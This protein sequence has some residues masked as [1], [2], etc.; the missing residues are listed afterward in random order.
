MTSR[1]TVEFLL[2]P[3]SSA[4]RRLRRTLAATACSGVVV[5]T[6][7]ELLARAQQ[8]YYI[9]APAAAGE[10]D[11]ALAES[12]DAFWHESF[13]KAPEE[14]AGAVRDALIDLLS[15]SHPG[16]CLESKGERELSPRARRM[17]GDLRELA[18]KLEE[19]LPGDLASLRNLLRADPSDAP[20]PLR[21]HRI[22]G[23]PYTTRWQDALIAKLN[24]DAALA[25]P[26]GDGRW[27]QVLAGCL[28]AKPRAKAGSA[29]A[30]LQARLFS[31]EDASVC[32]DQSAQWVRVRDFYQEAEVVAGMVQTLLAGNPDLRAAD[33][34]LLMPDS[35]E[36]SVAVEDAFRQAGLPLSGLAGERWRRDLGSEAVFHFLFCRQKPAPAMAQ[37]VCL[38]SLLMPWSAEDGA[39][40]AQRVMDGRYRLTAPDG[41]GRPAREMIKLIDGGDS[42]PATLSRALRDFASLLNGG[43][44][45]ADHSRRAKEAVDRACLRLEGAKGIDWP[46]LRRAVTPRYVRSGGGPTYTLEGVTVWSEGHEPWRQVRHLFVLGF[47]WGRYPK[48]LRASPVFSDDE[49]AEIRDRLGLRLDLPADKRDR[50]R[51]LFRRQLRAT[52]DSVTFMIPYRTPT[53]GT[54]SPSESLVFMQRLISPRTPRQDLVQDLDSLDDRKG[55]RHLAIAA[56]P[57]PVPPR[58]FRCKHL[59]LGRNLLKLRTGADGQVLPES[60]SSLELPLVSPLAWLLRQLDAEPLQW[61]PE[62]GDSLVVGS[63]AHS[64]FEEI[65]QPGVELPRPDEILSLVPAILDEATSNQAPFFRGPHWHA[66]RRN[67]ARQAARS[68][69]AWRVVLQKLRAEVLA[70][71]Q[72]LEGSWLGIPIHG[73]ADLILGLRDNR[74]LIVDYKWSKSGT[75]RKRMELGYECQASLYRTMAQTGGLKSWDRSLTDAEEQLA[76]RLRAA[77]WIGIAYYTMRDHVCLADSSLPEYGAVRGWDAV[78]GDVSLKA[79]AVI[80]LCL[81]ELRKGRVR[82][83]YET[84]RKR[85]E[86]ECGIAPFALD[87]SP[88]I[89]LFALPAPKDDA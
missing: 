43:E 75:R 38:S 39:R 54:Q 74:L 30:V 40:M 70:K 12:E 35:F 80:S 23:I 73:K 49:L 44:H 59:N 2:A 85:L 89:E 19:R 22:R 69:S 33:V 5:G 16:S 34:G 81:S 10:F 56:S 65:F 28:A 4:A 67:L 83:N 24:Q 79:S 64:I 29:L 51:R 76:E 32:A 42:E 53:G 26:S 11:P 46:E 41:A 63:L 17:F 3:D 8:A 47:E 14:S 84:D 62:S 57:E 18:S 60:P 36:Y 15:A 78:D 21:V 50:L 68:A 25:S 27:E 88:L 71:E 13:S 61:A 86:K 55:I 82:L 45:L 66:E 1:P 31:R 48:Q 37:A 52:S 87:A 6:W 77:D 72:W 9:A 20:Q 7:P 58:S